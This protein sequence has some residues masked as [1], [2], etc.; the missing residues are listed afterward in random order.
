MFN[1]LEARVIIW[2]IRLRCSIY[3]LNFFPFDIYMCYL[4]YV[5][6]SLSGRVFI[7]ND[8]L[9]IFLKKSLLM[10]I[11]KQTNFKQSAGDLSIWNLGYFHISILPLHCIPLLHCASYMSLC[12]SPSYL[13][14]RVSYYYPVCLVEFAE[15]ELSFNK[16]LPGIVVNSLN[17]HLEIISGH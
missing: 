11:K 16:W 1:R 5:G 4:Y 15:L 13:I 12:F 10:G 9:T 14:L 17:L 8:I 7:C 3:S 6:V 2:Q